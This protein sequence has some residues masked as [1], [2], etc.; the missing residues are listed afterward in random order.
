MIDGLPVL[1]ENDTEE[2]RRAFCEIWGLAITAV[3]PAP[4]RQTA[5]EDERSAL[6]MHHSEVE[7]TLANLSNIVNRTSTHKCAAY[8]LRT[9]KGDPL[10]APKHCRFH[11]PRPPNM[12]EMNVNRAEQGH[13]PPPRLT[14]KWHPKYLSFEAVRNDPN[15]LPFNQLAS[16]SWRANCDFMPC[17]RQ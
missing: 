8:C 4:G 13:V 17:T 9:K 1:K 15:V 12:D 3:N 16:M 6:Q 11:Y 7:N 2:N 5:P 14:D 10:S